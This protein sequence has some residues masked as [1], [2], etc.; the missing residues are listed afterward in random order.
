MSRFGAFDKELRM[1][2]RSLLNRVINA[3]SFELYIPKYQFCDLGTRLEKRLAR[4]DQRINSLDA[5]C[6]EQDIAY[7]QRSR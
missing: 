4:D 2:S 7:S 5:T 3:L 1:S 6:R